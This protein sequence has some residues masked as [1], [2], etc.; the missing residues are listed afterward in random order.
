MEV[1]EAQP[2]MPG[3]CGTPTTTD[4]LEMLVFM[5]MVLKFPVTPNPVGVVRLNS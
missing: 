3:V 5:T 2:Y 4:L 1:C